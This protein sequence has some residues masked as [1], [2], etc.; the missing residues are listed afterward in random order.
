MK[1]YSDYAARRTRQII[2]D[3]L[4]LAAIAAWAWLG[5]TVYGLVMNL[6]K[7]GVQMEES[8]KGFKKTMTDISENLSGI[9][10][11]GDGIKAPFDAASDA[12]ATLES[13][14]Q[15]QQ[16]A[17]QQLATGLGFGIAVLPI[18]T[19]LVFWLVPRIRFARRASVAKRMISQGASVDLLALRALAN[20]KVG[21]LLSIDADVAGAWRRS[22]PAVIRSLANLELRASG[23]KL[24]EVVAP[25][26]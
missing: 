26:A 6:A 10:L 21:A 13:A 14:G 5:W 16:V 22:D 18:L 25:S 3:L 9:W 17:V 4:A 20:Q 11:I 15:V 7:F 23:V 1:I 8:G 19:I 12:G 2:V 24:R